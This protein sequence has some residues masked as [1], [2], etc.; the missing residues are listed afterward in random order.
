MW[1]AGCLPGERWGGGTVYRVRQILTL[2]AHGLG[3]SM[4]GV[5]LCTSWCSIARAQAPTMASRKQG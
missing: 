5:T 2:T 4:G 3:D 1:C